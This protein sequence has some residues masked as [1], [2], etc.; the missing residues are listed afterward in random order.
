[1]LKILQ[2][3]QEHYNGSAMIPRSATEAEITQ[4]NTDLTDIGLESLPEDYAAFLKVCNGFAWNGIELYGTYQVS[5][6]ASSA[7]YTLMDIVT[8]SDDGDE[9]YYD[10]IETACLYFGRADEDVYTWNSVTKKYEVRDIS[11]ISD[12]MVEYGTI[13][14]FFVQEVG[15]RLGI[16]TDRSF[17]FAASTA[18][19]GE[20]V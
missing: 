18:G 6:P 12:V 11:C 5:D 20:Q 14:D 4:C 2:Y 10:R 15:G 16:H 9:R 1:M 17:N 3:L 8:M 13:V 19:V 7:G